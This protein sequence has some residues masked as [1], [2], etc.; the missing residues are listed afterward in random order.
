[1]TKAHRPQTKARELAGQA[2]EEY[3]ED[4]PKATE[5]AKSQN[6]SAELRSFILDRARTD[7][8]DYYVVFLAFA[9]LAFK[10]RS[11][12]YR[13]ATYLTELISFCEKSLLDLYGAKGKIIQHRE[14]QTYQIT[15]EH[16]S[17]CLSDDL[18]QFFRY[19]PA[20]LSER[21]ADDDY[22][23]LVRS[24]LAGLFLAAGSLTDPRERYSLE[25]SINKRS[26]SLWYGLFLSELDLEPGRTSHQGSQILYLKGGEKVADFLRYLGAD[27][28]LLD[29]EQV[30]VT[31]DMRNRVNRLVN[32]DS[33]N[34]QRLANSVAKQV[35][36][37]RYLRQHLNWSDLPPK[38]QEAAELRLNYPDYSLK[39]LGQLADPPLGKS[40]ISRRLQKINL[41]AEEL[42][43]GG[44]AR[45]TP[46]STKGE[47]AKG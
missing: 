2:P 45:P 6:P 24:I 30:R 26:T 23:R 17:R 10:K 1:M 16:L 36:S 20:S 9:S 43:A 47:S 39:D 22:F 11:Q 46:S 41:L 42:R 35:D 4:L 15:D 18:D 37:I 40:G 5:S 31:K 44:K 29:F 28:L 34:A 32:C 8:F 19:N 7:C 12:T 25:F 13:Y 33:A 3:P 38:L 14:M 27:R 21:K